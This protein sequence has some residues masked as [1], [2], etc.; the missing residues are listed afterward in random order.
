VAEGLGRVDPIEVAATEVAI[1]PPGELVGALAEPTAPAPAFEPVPA[2]SG[3]GEVFAL[4]IGIDDYPGSSA[5]LR[6]AVADADTI[7]AALDGFGVPDGN[8]VVLRDGQARLPD[9]VAAVQSFVSQG[10][11]GATLVLGY[12][13]HVRKLDSDTEA[14][15][16]ADGQM[17]RDRDLAAL[18]APAT[19]QRMWLVLATCFA[20][21]FTE[22][23]GPGRV[24]TGAAGANDLAYES[25]AL[26]A[27][28]LVH[29]M[30]RQAWLQGAAGR[31][32]QDA[33]GYAD[34]ALARDHPRRRPIQLDALGAPML[35]GVG[36]PTS[37]AGQAPPSP[38]Q[39]PREPNPPPSNPPP[40]N[41]PPSGPPTTERPP[42]EEE[43]CFLSLL[44]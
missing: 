35:L 31:S 4:I 2:A 11:A 3:S 34:A 39:P 12:A 7:D 14:L 9:V 36:D 37:A 16:L 38:S 27:S 44:C 15:V 25:R 8:R 29:Y 28:Y 42:G 17:L 22:L 40:S 24:L 10:D 30:V 33:F 41:P 18:L 6:A 5:D 26:N 23:L 13:G 43:D 20:G 21:G 19:A 32:V 1:T